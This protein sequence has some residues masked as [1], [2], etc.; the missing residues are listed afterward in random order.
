MKKLFMFLA[1]LFVGVALVGCTGDKPEPDPDP[2]PD[3][4]KLDIAL[5]E[6]FK[7]LV[8]DRHVYLTTI[9]QNADVDTVYNI[10]LSIFG[11]AGAEE[12]SLKVSKNNLLLA[13]E[14]EAGALVIIVPGASAKGMG[15]AGTDQSKEQTR[16][17]AFTTRASKNELDILVVHTGGS[18]RRGPSTSDPLITSVSTKAKL[19]LVVGNANSDDFFTNISEIHSV[20]AYY[21]TTAFKLVPAFK[22]L[23]N[24]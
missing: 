4:V 14:V 21:F 13:S 11:E 1:V 2:T 3:E 22:Q 9:G 15:A 24:K 19:M 16:G 6:E 10:I 5:A 20:P 8:G 18:Q 23:F 12:A 17:N 7:N